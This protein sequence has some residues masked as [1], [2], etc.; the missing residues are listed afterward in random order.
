MVILDDSNRPNSFV[1]INVLHA[2][3][4][5][6]FVQI[7]DAKIVYAI[8]PRVYTSRHC[9]TL[10][11]EHELVWLMLWL[12]LNRIVFVFFSLFTTI[13]KPGHSRSDSRRRASLVAYRSW[14]QQKWSHRT[15]RGNYLPR[16]FFYGI[17]NSRLMYP[18]YIRILHIDLEYFC[19]YTCLMKWN[20]AL[21]CKI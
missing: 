13:K 6:I 15:W 20:L 12:L 9:G 5:V 14:H 19:E 10:L 8:Y 2:V 16:L 18:W 3:Y 1:Q 17:V 21:T 4:S 11:F 7:F